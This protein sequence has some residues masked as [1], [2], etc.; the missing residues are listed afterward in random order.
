MI[1]KT[2][3]KRQAN[4]GEF[5]ELAK[6]S[7]NLKSAMASSRNFKYLSVDKREALEMIA[8]KISRILN[9][10]SRHKDSWHD[11]SGYATLI[12]NKLDKGD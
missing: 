1:E 6:V 7:Q 5:E 8:H 9:G 10:N 3:A 11:I 2:L 12:E 4:Y